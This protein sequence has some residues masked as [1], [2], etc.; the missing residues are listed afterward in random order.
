MDL[1][2]VD[3]ATL[4]F[5]SSKIFENDIEET[6]SYIIQEEK[7][8]QNKHLHIHSIMRRQ[9][10]HCL[11]LKYLLKNIDPIDKS[12]QRCQA[13]EKVQV[14]SCVSFHTKCCDICFLPGLSTD[15]KH[16]NGMCSGIALSKD[17]SNLTIQV[18]YWSNQLWYLTMAK[19]RLLTAEKLYLPI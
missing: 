3:S 10:A 1:L 16:S 2:E 15:L 19:E 13:M 9:M 17:M 14:K 12:G 11:N 5:Y 7:A 6:S 4:Y 18:I 8:E